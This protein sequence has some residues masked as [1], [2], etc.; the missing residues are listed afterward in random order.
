MA[1]SP[2]VMCCVSSSSSA[3]WLNACEDQ[4]KCGNGSEGGPRET[5]LLGAAVRENG[6]LRPCLISG[7]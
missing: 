2:S 1:S 7:I 5:E 3:F 6:S 4:D